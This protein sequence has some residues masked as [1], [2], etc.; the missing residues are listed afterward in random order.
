MSVVSSELGIC[1]LERWI[2]VGFWLLN[3]V[4]KLDVSI[5]STMIHA[6]C[7][8]RL[9]IRVDLSRVIRRRT[10]ER[11]RFGEPSSTGCVETSSWILK[12]CSLVFVPCTALYVH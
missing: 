5:L 7:E 12:E 10:V 9:T 1:S 11:T 3:T 8:D 4:R 2:S 6:R